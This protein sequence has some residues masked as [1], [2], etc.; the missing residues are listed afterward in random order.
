MGR[1]KKTDS[2]EDKPGRIYFDENT[3]AAIVRYNLSY[4]KDE[5][6]II[7]RSEIQRPLDKLAENVIN[8]F[9]FPYMN[10]SFEDTKGQV[11]SF[12]VMNLAKF[13]PEK[14]KKA[15]SYLSVI[16]KNYLIL[17]NNNAYKQQKRNVQLSDN[18]ETFIPIDEMAA[19]EAPD[20][21]QHEDTREF[22]D[23]MVQFWDENLTTI[24][25]KKRDI[26]IANAVVELFR[27]AGSIE[28]FNKK[29]LYLMIREMTDCKTSYIT[30]VV[31]KMRVHTVKH[32]ASFYS[33]GTLTPDKS[34][35]VTED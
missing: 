26:D 9:K 19:L 28:N 6:E 34:R 3:E 25:K 24:F 20:E 13:K 21:R 14:N 16:A 33:Q 2:V 35:F 27:N 10:Q 11:V 5:R 23:L 8:R 7:Y 17:Q 15:F 12:L 1:R 18:G 22:V 30:K 29:A 4:D 31:N 32:L